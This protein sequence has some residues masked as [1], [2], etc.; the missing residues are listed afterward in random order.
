[1]DF[2]IQ[3][4]SVTVLL[5]LLS[6]IVLCYVFV[7]WIT[8]PTRKSKN[9]YELLRDYV[10]NEGADPHL[11][12]KPKLWIHTSYEKNARQWKAFYSRDTSNLNEPYIHLT[13]RSI[14]N[15]CGNDFQICLI[16]DTTFSRLLP[17]WEYGDLTEIVEPRKTHVRKLGMALLLYSW[18][19]M[20]LPNSFICQRNL[21]SLFTNLTQQNTAFVCESRNKSVC[22]TAAHNLFLKNGDIIGCKKHHPVLQEYIEFLYQKYQ[23]KSPTYH[24][25]IDCSASEHLWWENQI[26]QGN[27]VTL[28]ATLLGTRSPHGKPIGIEDMMEENHLDL[29]P[30]FY[31]IWIPH[32]E[33][34]KRPKY[35]WFA[36]L[37][38][39]DVLKSNSILVKYLRASLDNNNFVD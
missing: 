18:G 15:H 36:V 22:V 17:N 16:D 28:C 25:Y 4:H 10:L 8:Y 26:T 11:R 38:M 21:I 34:L 20:T 30:D 14:L 27:A 24:S 32:D 39:D 13:V 23:L 1:M 2:R 3:F 5:V 12:N 6:T 7:Q 37:P 19:G 31:G 29:S 33:I 35:Q 9:E